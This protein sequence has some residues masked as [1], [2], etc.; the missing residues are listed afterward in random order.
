[1]KQLFSFWTRSCTGLSFLR[2]GKL[3]RTKSSLP[4]S[5]LGCTFQSTV[6]EG[7]TWAESCGHAELRSQRSELR[8]VVVAGICEYRR[9][10]CSANA[11][12]IYIRISMSPLLNIK[13]NMHRMKFQE[14]EQ[15]TTVELNLNNLQNS[16]SG[17][18]YF[19]SNHPKC[20]V[21]VQKSGQSVN[22]PEGSCLSG[23]ANLAV[24]SP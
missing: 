18:R 7:R 14:V 15:R 3:I 22:I 10:I 6:Q 24:E 23:K 2:K 9:E 17:G 19:S 5:L 21:L 8:E 11:P 20:W 1:M 4:S 12:E 16:Y 13:L